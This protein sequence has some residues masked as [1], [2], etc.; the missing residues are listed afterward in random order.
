[1]EAIDRHDRD[2]TRCEASEILINP[3][4]LDTVLQNPRRSI[5]SLNLCLRK[6]KDR[7]MRQ[8]AP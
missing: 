8:K 3:L 1:M 5:A 4:K 7:D 2:Q 6:A